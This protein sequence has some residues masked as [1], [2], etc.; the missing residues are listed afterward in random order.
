[1][2]FTESQ[3][4][5]TK[6]MLILVLWFGA[7]YPILPQLI[8]TWSGNS[9]DSHGMLVPIL[10]AYFVWQKKELLKREQADSSQLGFWILAVSMGVYLLSYTGGVTFV[11]RLMIVSSL[12]GIVL[13][14]YGTNIFKII[15]F[16][17]LF[18]FFMIPAPYSIISLVALPLQLFATNISAFVIKAVSIPVYQEGNM[19]YFAQTQL[20]VAEACSG[21]RSITALTMLSVL[22]VYLMECEVWKKIIILMSAIPIAIIAN[23]TRVTGTGILAHFFGGQVAR[24]FLHDFS[25]IAVFAFGL[26]VLFLEAQILKSIGKKK[27]QQQ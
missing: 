20:E 16:P 5:I 17:L 19:L 7:F 21:L 25:G 15:A 22:F 11:A 2:N 8:D 13:Y 4:S 1:M 27:E 26:A 23:I 12:I 18:A 3:R 9:N 6:L 14:V 24:G 10:C